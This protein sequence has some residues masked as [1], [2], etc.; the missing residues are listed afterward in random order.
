MFAIAKIIGDGQTPET[1]YTVNVLGSGYSAI[2]PSIDGRPKFGWALVKLENPDIATGTGLY[3][4]PNITTTTAV[5]DIP[6]KVKTEILA[7]LNSLGVDTS[8]IT[9]R[10]TL[11]DII[12]KIASHC[13][14]K[15]NRDVLK[16]SWTIG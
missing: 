1:A 8:W 16:R 4:F 10:T 9:S 6:S 14:A 2:I 15:I 11:R 5:K 7:K 12:V 13:D 3:K